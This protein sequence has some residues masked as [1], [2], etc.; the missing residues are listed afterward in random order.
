MEKKR[1]IF[2]N[3][4]KVEHKNLLIPLKTLANVT[5]GVCFNIFFSENVQIKTSIYKFLRKR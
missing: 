4:T 1:R 3:D 5:L 2:Y